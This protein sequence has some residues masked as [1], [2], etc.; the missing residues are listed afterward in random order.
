MPD[1]N[2][3]LVRRAMREFILIELIIIDS[4][5]KSAVKPVILSNTYIIHT[6]SYQLMGTQ[7]NHFS[8]NV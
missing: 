1:L 5:A 8:M 6:C 2:D 7:I 3:W 4:N